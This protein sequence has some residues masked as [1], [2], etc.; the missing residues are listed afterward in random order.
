MKT[1]IDSFQ[2]CA[3]D[4]SDQLSADFFVEQ[5]FNLYSNIIRHFLGAGYT[6]LNRKERVPDLKEFI[7]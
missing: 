7:Y 2:I 4:R 6:E 3:E 1:D 5:L